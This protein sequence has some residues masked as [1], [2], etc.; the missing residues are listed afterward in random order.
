MGHNFPCLDND[1]E[2]PLIVCA[3]YVSLVRPDQGSSLSG[4]RTVKGY[5][6]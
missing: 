3:G 2:L 6:L 5:S 1:Q 4:N